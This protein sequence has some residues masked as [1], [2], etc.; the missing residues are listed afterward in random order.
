MR[1]WL[2][3]KAT[4]AQAVCAQ[5]QEEDAPFLRLLPA[6]QA[7]ES[8]KTISAFHS[9]HHFELHITLKHTKFKHSV[10]YQ[11]LATNNRAW[12]AIQGQNT[13]QFLEI[14]IIQ[15]LKRWWWQVPNFASSVCF[16]LSILSSSG[17]TICWCCSGSRVCTWG[18]RKAPCASAW[19]WVNPTV[20][21]AR[22]GRRAGWVGPRVWEGGRRPIAAKQIS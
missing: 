18:C 3:T 8:S 19:W 16:Q 2:S 13:T 7:L 20:P 4:L 1:E 12:K 10:T 21:G 11:L 22:V 17:A 5:T 9:S 6:P 15:M 14:P